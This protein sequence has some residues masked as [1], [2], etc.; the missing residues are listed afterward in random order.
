MKN[1]D[2][3]DLGGVILSQSEE[4]VYDGWQQDM[5]TKGFEILYRTSQKAELQSNVREWYLHTFPTDDLGKDIVADVAFSD[6]Y[7]RKSTEIYEILGIEDSVIRERVGDQ[8]R[9][10]TSPTEKIEIPVVKNLAQLKR[11]VKVGMEF[12]ITDHTRPECVGEKRIITGVST[13]DFTSRK[14][15]ETGEPY[16][17]DIHMDFG[18]AKNWNF[19]ENELTAY[20]EDGSL[21]MQFHFVEPGMLTEKRRDPE[22]DKA[23]NYINDFC[24]DEYSSEADLSNLSNIFIAYTTDEDTDMEI[25]VTADLEQFRMLYAYGNSIVRT[26]Q[27]ESLEEMNRN[28]LSVLDFN[29]LVTLSDDEKESVRTEPLSREAALQL[30]LMRGTGFVGGKFRVSDYYADHQPSQKEF[31]VFLKDEYGIGGHSGITPIYMANHGASGI[32]IE[33][34]THEKYT[35]KWNE[36]AKE[37]AALLDAGTYITSKDIQWHIRDAKNTIEH[38]D[39]V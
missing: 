28:V 6:L 31:A 39:P 25:Q 8:L 24:M 32:E 16:G 26:E 5:L 21:L 36:V 37:T 22:L 13:V 7:G 27:Y 38:Y 33:L 19:D 10:I 34:E 3:P 15:D 18:K 17:K 23:I 14:L 11:T 30:E 20:L 12:E 35:Y 4:L 29:D 2:A 1:L 9:E